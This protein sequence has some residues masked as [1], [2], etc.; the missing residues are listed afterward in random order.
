M[1]LR[2]VYRSWEEGIRAIVTQ[3]LA[4]EAAT[5]NARVFPFYRADGTYDS[6]SLLLGT[7]LPFYDA[8]GAAKNIK[9]VA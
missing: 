9:L 3:L 2:T 1:N 4:F 8:S 6:I 7:E 5:I